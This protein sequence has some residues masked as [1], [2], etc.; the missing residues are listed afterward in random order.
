MRADRRDS[1]EFE[2]VELRHNVYINLLK[3]AAMVDA[4]RGKCFLKPF[5]DGYLPEIEEAKQLR[6]DI[7]E[8]I[9]LLTIEKEWNDIM[10]KI[11]DY[12]CTVSAFLTRMKGRDK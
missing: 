12:S 3:A 5:D 11:D 6:A 2:L 4:I 10:G 8:A 7:A 9:R 1:N